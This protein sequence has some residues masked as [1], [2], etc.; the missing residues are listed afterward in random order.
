[1]VEAAGVEPASENAA[2]QDPTCVSPFDVSRP[3]RNG[4]KS[5]GR[6]SRNT[7]PLRSGRRATT[8]LLHDGQPQVAGVLGV[9]AHCLSSESELRIRSYGCSTGLTRRW[10]SARVPRSHTPVE[11]KSPPARQDGRSQSHLLF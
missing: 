9:T 3:D 2:S 7:S 5:P 10:P 8:S 4:A 6:P 11:A 1:M